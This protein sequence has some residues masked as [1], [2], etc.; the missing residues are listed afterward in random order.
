MLN[1]NNAAGRR[2]LINSKINYKYLIICVFLIKH[3]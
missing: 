3:L 1:R 2:R